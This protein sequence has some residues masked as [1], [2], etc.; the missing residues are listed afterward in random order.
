MRTRGGL[1]ALCVLAAVAGVGCEAE[2]S[3]WRS[4]LVSINGA[5][6]DAGNYESSMPVFSPDGT[7]V[8]FTS[9]AAD[10]GTD[11]GNGG[12]D[13]YVRDLAT[14]TTSRVIGTYIGRAI[15]PAFSPDGSAIAFTSGGTHF[16]PP[17]ANGQLDVYVRELGPEGL[18]EFTLVSPNGAGTSGGNGW[19][20]GPVFSPDGTK[21]AFTSNAS[22]LGPPDTNGAT[23]VYVRD[24]VAGTTTLVSMNGDRNDSGNGMSLVPV[25][26]PSGTE[27]A[28]L[29]MA[30]DL[31]PTDTN[32]LGDLYVRDLVTGTTT[33][34]TVN[35]AGTRAGNAGMGIDR[36]RFSGDGSRLA[37]A[38]SASDLVAGD[39]NG[40]GDVFVRD[41]RAGT[42]TLASVAAGGTRSGGNGGSSDPV[43]SPDGTKVV[44]TSMASDLGPNDSPRANPD[45]D[46]DIYVR[47]LA[48]G[49]TTLLSANAAGDDSGAAQSFGPV[50]SPDGTKV[51]FG[52]DAGD[53]GPTDTNGA[54]DLYVHD[55]ASGTTMLVSAAADGGDTA[56][57]SSY[58]GR[59][60]FSPDSSRIAFESEASGFGP[61]D[62]N[63]S[64][65]V[66]LAEV[67]GAD[68]AVTLDAA[69]LTV[70][71]GGQVTYRVELANDGPDP[72]DGAAFGLVVPAGT[73]VTSVEPHGATCT[74]PTPEHPDLVLCDAGNLAPGSRVGATV[75]VTVADGTGQPLPPT[76]V[77]VAV[78]SSDTLDPAHANDTARAT[79]TI[80]PPAT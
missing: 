30:S 18:L 57:G 12:A 55:L 35:A 73:D 66:Y 43:L 77:A 79:I 11:Y 9:S 62:T 53:L 23:D 15:E 64:R 46:D 38:S 16:G 74:A 68:L 58:H 29:S 61:T 28:F 19:S 78:K 27:I 5:G 39:H 31:G 21:V 63:G 3:P 60:A 49:T 41:L 1:A 56:A 10:L 71:A 72:A 54:S 80:T 48:A 34:V 2:P 40:Q 36:P 6:T 65:D 59:P 69:P 76:A 20:R 7:E 52:S 32:G 24:L 67:R 26:S 42:T 51:A 22:D 44:F 50:L 70:A 4:T 47:D 75:G 8:A 33:L 37:F 17:D 25:F 45:Y 14:G 13:A